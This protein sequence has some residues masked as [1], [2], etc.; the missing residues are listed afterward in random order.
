[1]TCISEEESFPGRA[2]LAHFQEPET[3]LLATLFAF[4]PEDA[5]IVGNAAKD[6][7]T[8]TRLSIIY[9]HRGA[10]GRTKDEGS[11]TAVISGCWQ[12]HIYCA[13]TF[14]VL[15]VLCPSQKPSGLPPLSVF[16]RVPG[17]AAEKVYRHSCGGN[18][19]IFI[20]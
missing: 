3:F 12:M 13:I 14:A 5:Q 1:M 6:A 20:S 17:L 2:P 18:G 10:S 8:L 16:L 9:P 11:L 7:A 4:L 15:D 19:R